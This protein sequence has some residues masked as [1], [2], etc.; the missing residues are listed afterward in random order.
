MTAPAQPPPPPPWA[1]SNLTDAEARDLD[2][3]VQAWVGDYNRHLATKTEEV[4]PACWRQHLALTQELPVQVHGWRAAH[5]DPEATAHEAMEYYTR[6]L[7]SLRDRVKDLLGS[8]PKACLAGKHPAED[9]LDDLITRAATDLDARGP[10]V[11]DVLMETS[12]AP[13]AVP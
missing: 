8:D 2:T 7:P 9:D 4:I 1:W 11:I 6:F 10:D 13:P 3:A 5:V 12:F